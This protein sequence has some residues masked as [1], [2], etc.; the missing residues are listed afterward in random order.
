MNFPLIALAGFLVAQ[1]EFADKTQLAV[2]FTAAK[3][4]RPVIVALMSSIALILATVVGVIAG[5]L[6][7]FVIPTDLITMMAAVGFI[8][9]GVY[10]LF[11]KDDDEENST[12]SNK[13]LFGIVSLVFLAEMG[14]KTQLAVILLSAQTGGYFEVF[15]GASLGL[16]LVTVFGVIIGQKLRHFPLKKV[17]IA[18]SI[19][20]ILIGIIMLIES[21]GLF[22]FL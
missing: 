7:S 22:S 17:K 4:G 21:L 15:V 12:E 2:I 8:I 16:A 20:F 1:A 11:E 18:G 9:M 3:I 6:V 14:D 19:L 10:G 13:T 5:G